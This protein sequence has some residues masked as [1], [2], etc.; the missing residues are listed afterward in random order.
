M[1]IGNNHEAPTLA[2]LLRQTHLLT[3]GLNRRD[4][5]YETH[6]NSAV[7]AAEVSQR[8]ESVLQ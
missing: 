3:E 4:S 1:D 7:F 5:S 8:S 6:S 2:H